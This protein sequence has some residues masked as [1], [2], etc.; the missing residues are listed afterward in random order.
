MQY[1]GH[2]L[3]L[4]KAYGPNPP[5]LG[6]EL[7]LL[8]HELFVQVQ[9]HLPNPEKLNQLPQVL[10]FQKNGYWLL[11]L[12]KHSVEVFL[13]WSLLFNLCFKF[14]PLRITTTGVMP[15]ANFDNASPAVIVETSDSHCCLPFLCI[16]CQG[17]F[18]R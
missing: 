14:G 8:L 10:L 17:H 18:N 2:S 15:D 6:R 13:S 11:A 1:R 3:G 9:L 16:Q 12:L 7:L 5:P 4:I